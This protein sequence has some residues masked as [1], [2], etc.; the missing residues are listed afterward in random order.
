M[1]NSITEA[2][3]LGEESTLNRVISYIFGAVSVPDHWLALR[4]WHSRGPTTIPLARCQAVFQITSHLEPVSRIQWRHD[5]FWELYGELGGKTPKRRE[6]LKW[7]LIDCRSG[8]ENIAPCPSSV[9]RRIR[10]DVG[11]WEIITALGTAT[12][13]GFLDWHGSRLDDQEWRLR[14]EIMRQIREE[15]VSVRTREEILQLAR[16]ISP[17]SWERFCPPPDEHL[18]ANQIR[19]W[20]G[21]TETNTVTQWFADGRRLLNQ[22]NLTR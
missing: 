10:P 22:A 11:L 14:V 9:C 5:R 19:A 13:F 17:L 16:G 6:G 18:L 20:L 8:H 4:Q 15:G 3:V 21:K 12:S 7:L 2:V 1:N